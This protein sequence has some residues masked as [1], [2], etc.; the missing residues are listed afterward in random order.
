MVDSHSKSF[1]GQNTGIIVSSS[2][3]SDP[4]TFMHCFKKKPNGIWEKPSSKE[5][6]SIKFSL[7]E[8]VLILRVL[9][10][11]TL[12]WQNQHSY[13]ENTTSISFNWEDEEAEVLWI[14]IGK[15]SKRLSLAQTEI[16]KLLLSHFLQEKIIHSTL[17]KKSAN[18][19]KAKNLISPEIN[20]PKEFGR[21][22]DEDYETKLSEPVIRGDKSN[23][24]SDIDGL[25]VGETDKAFLIKFDEIEDWVPKSAI[26][27]HS[28]AQK[29]TSQKLLIDNWI[30]KKL[31][32]IP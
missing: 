26:N 10:R 28:I 12:N 8:I 24:M 6:K 29:N 13:K 32:L 3:S 17:P 5:G 20:K 4:F 23:E 30:L 11:Q 2:S 27:N 25:I 18:K 14:N 21:N 19:N 7:E 16:L 22:L 31:H 1:F 15:Y 9:N